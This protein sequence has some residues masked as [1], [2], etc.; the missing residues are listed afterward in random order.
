[1]ARI[2]G[3]KQGVQVQTSEGR[4]LRAENPDNLVEQAVGLRIPVSGLQY[5]VKGLPDP[6]EPSVL[7]GDSQGRLTVMEQNGWL[8]EY[9]RYTQIASLDLPARIKARQDD[10]KVQ[11]VVRQWTV[12]L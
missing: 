6:T 2:E 9:P 12:H 3:N 4:I 8:I 11:V 5:W 1:M 7:E 10:L